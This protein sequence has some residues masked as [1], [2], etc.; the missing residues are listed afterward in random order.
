M[1]FYTTTV[2]PL[3]SPSGV[4][5]ISS[6]FEGGLKTMVSVLHKE[7]EY[8]VEELGYKKFY[9]V[10]GGG[11]GGDRGAGA[12]ETGEERAGGGISTMA[13]S[14]REIK[15]GSQRNEPNNVS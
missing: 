10:G 6:P 3:I 8:K 2:N 11:G 13:G 4:L 1:T 12:R 9:P 15:K 5:F 14:G 7:L